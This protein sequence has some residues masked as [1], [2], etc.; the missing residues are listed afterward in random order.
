[1]WTMFAILTGGIDWSKLAQPAME[2]DISSA[3]I[4]ATSIGIGF[5]ILLN[6]ITA[7]IVEHAM[8]NAKVDE[9]NLA[10]EREIQ[11]NKDLEE[12]LACFM[13]LDTDGTGS[14]DKDE[15]SRVMHVPKLNRLCRILDVQP[16]DLEGLFDLMDINGDGVLM[17]DEFRDVFLS[18]MRPCQSKHLVGTCI[19]TMRCERLINEIP[20]RLLRR[21]QASRDS[22]SAPAP[23]ARKGCEQSKAQASL[24]RAPN[25]T[26]LHGAY[27]KQFHELQADMREAERKIDKMAE[28][29]ERL[30]DRP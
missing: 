15:M 28:Y 11:R 18:L 27:A 23:K 2:V 24:H 4:F 7:V 13:D 21:F 8:H 10:R 3:A 5:F 30:M 9:E 14:L 26:I 22:L 19:R 12:L 20:N 29:V 16:D 1:M 6:L 17:L 25:M